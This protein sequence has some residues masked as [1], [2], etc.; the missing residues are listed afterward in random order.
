[1]I[2]GVQVFENV[3]MEYLEHGRVPSENNPCNQ[4]CN[5]WIEVG[6]SAVLGN[7]WDF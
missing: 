1:M 5:Q 2:D 4:T 6:K 7:V 3:H